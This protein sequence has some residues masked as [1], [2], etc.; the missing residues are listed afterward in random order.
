MFRFWQ[1]DDDDHHHHW[2]IRILNYKY[3]LMK[4]LFYSIYR[5]L[6]SSLS[7]SYFHYHH[8]NHTNQTKQYFVYHF[9]AWSII[10]YHKMMSNLISLLLVMFLINQK[11]KFLTNFFFIPRFMFHAT[12][13]INYS[14]FQSLY[15]FK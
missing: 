14:F 3:G 6:I 5:I 9:H 2:C 10:I 13:H 1:S 7:F 12:T 4:I 8:H 11:K 15:F